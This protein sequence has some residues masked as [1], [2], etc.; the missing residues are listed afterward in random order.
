MIC[1]FC[2]NSTFIPEPLESFG[3]SLFEEGI[4]RCS[5]NY[6]HPQHESENVAPTMRLTTQ[7]WHSAQIVAAIVNR[8]AH[9]QVVATFAQ[10]SKS[11]L[12]RRNH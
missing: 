2:Y 6:E 1:H 11:K 3:G 5:Q 9:V 12:P 7:I 10:V 8:T 4:E